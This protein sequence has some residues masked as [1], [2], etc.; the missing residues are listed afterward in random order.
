MGLPEMR[1]P[2][3]Q[4]GPTPYDLCSDKKGKF[5]H[6]ESRTE[7]YDVKRHGEKTAI[8]ILTCIQ[9]SQKA[10]QVVW[11]SHLFQNFPQ[12]IVIQNI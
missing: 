6:R 8:Y 4:V 12:F 11:Y 1:S 5:G 2:W 9:I 3:I 10:D 7:E